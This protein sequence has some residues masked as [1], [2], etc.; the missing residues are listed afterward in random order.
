[1]ELLPDPC[2]GKEDPARMIAAAGSQKE[3]TAL[4]AWN[5][6]Q[7]E[8]ACYHFSTKKPSGARVH[9]P[10][11]KRDPDFRSVEEAGGTSPQRKKRKDANDLGIIP[12]KKR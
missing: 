12:E 7:G 10:P 4:P 11:S 1:M 5:G 6:V 3:G 2:G 9:T 8:A